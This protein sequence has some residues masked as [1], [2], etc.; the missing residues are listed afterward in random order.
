MEQLYIFGTNKVLQCIQIT[1]SII[2][3]TN[4]PLQQQTSA[5]NYNM[6]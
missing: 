5:D 4:L 3:P 2:Y 6:I 1:I